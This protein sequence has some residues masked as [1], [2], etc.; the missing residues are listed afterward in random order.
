MTIRDSRDE[1]KR[2]A[3]VAVVRARRAYCAADCRR[4]PIVPGS[5]RSAT[6]MVVVN[7][8]DPTDGKW[9][10]IEEYHPECYETSGAQER[11]GVPERDVRVQLSEMREEV[12]RRRQQ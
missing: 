9:M 4:G 6:F 2:T 3:R 11:Y 7:L 5:G 8:Y 1:P 10:G 12:R